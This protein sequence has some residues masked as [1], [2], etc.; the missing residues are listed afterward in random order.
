MARTVPTFFKVEDPV[1]YPPSIMWCTFAVMHSVKMIDNER[2]REVGN[3]RCFPVLVSVMLVIRQSLVLLHGG[4]DHI[5]VGGTVKELRGSMGRSHRFWS[6]K[7]AAKLVI[8]YTLYVVG[9]K[10][11]PEY[12]VYLINIIYPSSSST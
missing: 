3:S 1:C 2:A 8:F 11:L 12:K 5:D 4:S 9:G 6:I 10:L 7:C